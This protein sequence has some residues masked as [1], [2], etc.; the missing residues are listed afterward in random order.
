MFGYFQRIQRGRSNMY[1]VLTMLKTLDRHS[2]EVLRDAH[3]HSGS[4]DRQDEERALDALERCIEL[5]T[6]EQDE[7]PTGT[8]AR[9]RPASS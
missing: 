8:A 2:W 7:A 1:R 4:V 9:A 5:A 6:G 3:L